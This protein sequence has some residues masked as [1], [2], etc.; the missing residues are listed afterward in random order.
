MDET[1][2]VEFGHDAVDNAVGYRTVPDLDQGRPA[3]KA[4][5]DDAVVIARELRAF[6]HGTRRDPF[7]GLDNDAAAGP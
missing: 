5:G 4:A 2:P 1:E 7:R 3:A 6:D